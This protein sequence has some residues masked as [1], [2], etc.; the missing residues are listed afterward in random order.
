LTCK[1]GIPACQEKYSLTRTRRSTVMR[2]ATTISQLRTLA[3][4]KN[5]SPVQTMT[6]RDSTRKAVR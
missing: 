6:L 4:T 5:D 2:M 3:A 1:I